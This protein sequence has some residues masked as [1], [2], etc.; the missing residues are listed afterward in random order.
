MVNFTLGFIL[1]MAS[2]AA[3]IWFALGEDK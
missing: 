1:G 2:F 3:I